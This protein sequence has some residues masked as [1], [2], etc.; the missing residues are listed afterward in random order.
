MHTVQ[1]TV[2]LHR[3][4]WNVDTVDFGIARTETERRHGNANN[5]IST[6]CGRPLDLPQPSFV[7]K[8]SF[9]LTRPLGEDIA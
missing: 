3:P 9:L 6:G 5:D 8:G 2:A 7:S 1:W 4:K